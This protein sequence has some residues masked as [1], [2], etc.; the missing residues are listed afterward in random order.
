MQ[1][2]GHAPEHSGDSPT[3]YS[4]QHV[5]RAHNDRPMRGPWG[6]GSDTEPLHR[7][8]QRAFFPAPQ[9]HKGN[10]RRQKQYRKLWEHVKSVHAGD[11]EGGRQL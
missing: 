9:Q 4:S 8:D 2:H 10:V 11:T 7:G 5:Q 6:H 3:S 1:D